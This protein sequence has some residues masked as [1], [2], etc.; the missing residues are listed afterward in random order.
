MKTVS[1][2]RIHEVSRH[3]RDWEHWCSTDR[4]MGLGPLDKN[5]EARRCHEHVPPASVPRW[6]ELGGLRWSHV[7]LP[8]HSEE[9]KGE[10]HPKC[11]TEG[12]QTGGDGTE[13]MEQ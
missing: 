4:L 10:A 1:S 7:R 3:L 6:I 11:R 13:V 2:H 12:P 5:L 8:E 9:A